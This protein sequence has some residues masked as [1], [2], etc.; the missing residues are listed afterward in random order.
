MDARPVNL[1]KC[2][3]HKVQVL[4]A[5]MKPQ[6]NLISRPAK[7]VI[8]RIHLTIESS[9][10]AFLPTQLA[11]ANYNGVEAFSG[12]LPDSLSHPYPPISKEEG[13][14]CGSSSVP[15]K[16]AHDFEPNFP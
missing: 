16:S 15:S 7:Q 3:H 9:C 4:E 13:L 11:D 12:L 6:H 2:N 14:V 1:P 8:N 5:S 10:V